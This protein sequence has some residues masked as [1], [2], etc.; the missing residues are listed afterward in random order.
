[1][2]P[3]SILFFFSGFAAL[4]YELVWFRRLGL[5]FGNTVH[6]ASTVL[7]AYMLGLALGA[8]LAGRIAPRAKRPV[9]LFALMEI[10]I[11]LYALC[12]PTLF[13]MVTSAYRYLYR[14]MD[15]WAGALTTVRFVLAVLVLLVP[16]ACMGAT[17]PVLAQGLLAKRRN[18]AGRLGIL[19]GVNTAGAMTG[20]IASGFAL[21]PGLGMSGASSAAVAA[22]LLVGAGAWLLSM[23]MAEAAPDVGPDNGRRVGTR[24]AGT[25]LLLVAI[26]MSGLISL[27]F[28]VAWFRALILVFGSTT[29][30]FAVMLFIFLFGIALG[31]M[32]LGRLA[33][34]RVPAMLV[35]GCAL[36]GVGAYTLASM[37]WFSAFPEY[38]LR[39]LS[40]YGMTWRNMVAAKAGI[41]CVFLLV[42]A[43]G[44]GAAFPAGVRAVRGA[45]GSASRSVGACYTFNT[46]GAALGA[47][48]AGFVLLSGIGIERAL[49]ALATVALLLGTLACVGQ[50]GSPRRVA[51]AVALVSI[52][53]AAAS[54]LHPPRWDRQ[55]LTSGP[56]FSPWNFVRDGRIGLR[57]KMA[58]ERLLFYSEGTAAVVATTRGADENLYFLMDGK[59]EADTTPRS[60]MLQRM[61]GHLPMLFHPAPKR[62]L[63][64]GLG[65][66]VTFGALSCY[67]VERLEAVE[68]EPAVT[69]VACRWRRYNHGIMAD[70]RA[71]VTITDGRNHLLCTTNRYDVITSDPF[72]PV[73]AGAANLY[74]LE[75]FVQARECLAAGG[76]MCQY[77]PLYELSHD[78]F[79]A[80]LRAFACAFPRGAVFFAGCDTLLLGA[81]DEL[82]LGTAALREKFEIPAVAESLAELGF[83]RPEEVLCMFAVDLAQNT[84]VV[85]LG[86]PNTDDRPVVEFSAPRSALNYT[87]DKNQRVLLDHFSD[88]PASLVQGLSAEEQERVREG[89]E[90]LKVILRASIAR[91]SGRFR[92]AR[93][94]LQAVSHLSPANPVVRN[95]LVADLVGSGRAYLAKGRPGRAGERFRAAL[96]H[97]PDNFWALYHMAPIAMA[98]GRMAD[99]ARHIAAGLEAYPGSPLFLALR[100]KYRGIMGHMKGARRDLRAALDILPNKV[101]LWETYAELLDAMGDAT[102]ARDARSRAR[103]LRR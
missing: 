61:M 82:R 20:V 24:R 2:I 54:L 3:V 83:S 90:A 43:A 79:S 96:E 51:G 60:M 71:I 73:M 32:L 56:Y 57:D 29:Y 59:V 6:A 41:A 37:Y 44:F 65:A 72:E 40:R 69:E 17:L 16:T 85:G 97:D 48:L 25:A 77:L 87:S 91:S 93:D 18:F 64:I 14:S 52:V 5:I 47:C 55:L 66:G 23:R 103:A 80:I 12:V 35:F 99:A 30:S 36:A 68:I 28:E 62:V 63:N 100:G 94:L 89:H 92:E 26:G 19:Y 38:L 22:S 49:L 15:A 95:E 78:D 101:D 11:G 84:G 42:P 9:R 98:S 10:A 39:F 74:T 76:V 50:A 46:I 8:H 102:E 88:I 27:A 53:C 21:I 81:R 1:M 4:V 33:D 13:S 31:A 70:P 86:A 45:V 58:S 67:P 7:T 75:H 34:R